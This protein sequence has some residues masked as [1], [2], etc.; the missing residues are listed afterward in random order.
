[1]PGLGSQTDPSGEDVDAGCG[2]A[3]Q[4]ER[5]RRD[6]MDR[7]AADLVGGERRFRAG[8][9]LDLDR[10]GLGRENLAEQRVPADLKFDGQVRRAEGESANGCGLGPHA[11]GAIGVAGGVVGEL[12]ELG[13]DVVP[14]EGVLAGFDELGRHGPSG[15]ESLLQRREECVVVPAFSHRAH[16]LFPWLSVSLARLP[17]T[18]V[19]CGERR[20]RSRHR[21]RGGPMLPAGMPSVALMPA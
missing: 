15:P 7:E 6:G 11:W 3:M 9:G 17:R 12:R 14:R 4:A 5:D 13:V 20:S 1:M 18:L 19:R 10:G 2:S 16:L 8:A 21:A